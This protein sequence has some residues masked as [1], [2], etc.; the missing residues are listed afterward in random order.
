MRLDKNPDSCSSF[1]CKANEGKYLLY[2]PEPSV[3]AYCVDAASALVSKCPD[4][5]RMN[6]FNGLEPCKP[7]CT[8]AGRIADSETANAYYNCIELDNGRLSPPQKEYCPP[9]MVFS[10]AAKRCVQFDTTTPPP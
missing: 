9:G 10:T 8:S 5:Y 4:N 3:Y 7:Y 2:G 6:P 1:N